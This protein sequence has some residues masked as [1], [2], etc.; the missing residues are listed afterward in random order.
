MID[1]IFGSA[2]PKEEAPP[3]QEPEAPTPVANAGSAGQSLVVPPVPP[4]IVPRPMPVEVSS[5]GDRGATE[6]GPAGV[7]SEGDDGQEAE[8]SD[9]DDG[10]EPESSDEDEERAERSTA[11]D[12]A[13]A[14]RVSSTAY[15]LTGTMASGR[16]VY[17]GAAAMNGTPLGSRYQVL[18]GPRAGE[19]FVVEDRIGHGS[20]F[21]IAYPGDCRGAYNYG[22]RTISIRPV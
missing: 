22:R 4:I 2:F 11:E 13:S 7:S 12:R 5:A 3:A 20:A 17:S 15:C 8:S 10:Q 9:E 6:E 18:D 19:T 21:D 16:T 1:E 14:R